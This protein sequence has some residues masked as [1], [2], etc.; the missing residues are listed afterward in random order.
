M[1]QVVH[2]QI[3]KWD[4]PT[5]GDSMK[6][7][8]FAILISVFG[9]TQ[10]SEASTEEQRYWDYALSCLDEIQDGGVYAGQ[11]YE[12]DL[13]GGSGEKSV[14][15]GEYFL[16]G[17]ARVVLSLEPGWWRA[18]S[19]WENKDREI[20]FYSQYM[21]DT[22]LVSGLQTMVFP[23]S[24]YP[25]RSVQF[26]I[27]GVIPNDSDQLWFNGVQAWRDGKVWRAGINKPWNL[28]G[29]DVEI[30][31]IGHG[32]WRMTVTQA[33]FGTVLSFNP[34]VMDETLLAPTTLNVVSFL[35]NGSYLDDD[36][37]QYG[38]R[39]YSQE[40]GC[41]ILELESKFVGNI[42]EITIVMNGYNEGSERWLNYKTV[43]LKNVSGV[44]LVPIGEYWVYPQTNVR[45]YLVDPRT[46]DIVW[47]YLQTDDLQFPQPVVPGKD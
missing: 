16:V 18:Y 7:F 44:F 9:F 10:M 36:L 33:S 26:E 34:Q 22:Y 32:G 8:L 4:K 38:G 37:I 25:Y 24:V 12:S 39:Y 19:T 23:M 2:V 20:L 46:G 40:F 15:F 31:W 42:S 14:A 5:E 3:T 6:K 27:P 30:I 21:D 28:I 43:S 41:W 17:I 11:I 45:V 47:R 13:Q 35:E 29:Q 1:I